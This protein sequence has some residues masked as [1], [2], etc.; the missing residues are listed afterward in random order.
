MELPALFMH[1][2]WQRF[3]VVAL[4]AAAFG[5]GGLALGFGYAWQS[6]WLRILGWIAAAAA[7]FIWVYVRRRHIRI[8]VDESRLICA[9]PGWLF[10]WRP[11]SA[12]EFLYSE[13]TLV[14]RRSY[15]GEN[16]DPACALVSGS[17]SC[18]IPDSIPRKDE[19]I[20]HLRLHIPRIDEKVSEDPKRGRIPLE[21]GAALHYGSNKR[22]VA[23]MAAAVFSGLLSGFLSK[24]GVE[25]E[26]LFDVLIMPLI[27][28]GL[29]A[30]ALYVLPDFGARMWVDMSGLTLRRFG[31][32][33]RIE[34]KHLTGVTFKDGL[35]NERMI[36]RSA[37]GPVRIYQN[38]DR[39]EDLVAL[40]GRVRPD[41]VDVPE[42]E[43]PFVLECR[44]LRV[45][46]FGVFLS[47]WLALSVGVAVVLTREGQDISMGFKQAWLSLLFFVPGALA[48]VLY[49]V[50]HVQRFVFESEFVTRKRTFWSTV[51][52][53]NRLHR[54][55]YV[56]KDQELRRIVLEFSPGLGKVKIPARSTVLPLRN[57][58]ET[59]GRIYPTSKRL[60]ES[61]DVVRVEP[62][63][64]APL[65][66]VE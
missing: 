9:Q 7:A 42:P 22:G 51:K 43:L 16:T 61:H 11:G 28:M 65:G 64:S 30:G 26:G 63:A 55:V 31:I 24:H 27:V 66:D 45:W 20:Q 13:A 59:L 10:W 50:M 53:T 1:D 19:L 36:L 14:I 17:R 21:Y 34:F 47:A 8:V 40:I 49:W 56:Q 54:I 12:D 23:I 35:M 18:R 6:S 62:P 5:V 4:F 25:V 46:H 37:D 38:L 29:T 39:Y 15:T 33:K 2:K 52:P 60:V 48:A 44:P 41:L 58:L 57:V 32:S 3:R